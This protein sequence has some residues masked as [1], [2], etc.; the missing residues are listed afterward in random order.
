MCIYKPQLG[1]VFEAMVIDEM[2]GNVV[3]V[4]DCYLPQ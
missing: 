4:R 1:N 2:E 3:A